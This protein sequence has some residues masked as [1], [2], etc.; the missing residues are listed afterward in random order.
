[1]SCAPYGRWWQ[2]Q[3]MQQPSSTTDT[4]V[5]ECPMST[6]QAVL[7]FAWKEAQ[8]AS[9]STHTAAMPMRESNTCAPH[10]S[11]SLSLPPQ[12]GLFSG[13]QVQGTA[14]G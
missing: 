12:V 6:M 2:Q 3:G 5:F 7:V 1:M 11:T 14:R 4:D 9:C 10:A 13:V 8:A